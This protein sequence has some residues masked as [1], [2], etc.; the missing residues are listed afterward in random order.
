[1]IDHQKTLKLV[2]KKF[3]PCLLFSATTLDIV[4]GVSPVMAMGCGTHPDKADIIYEEDEHDCQQK[5]SASYLLL[6]GGMGVISI[7]A[8][9]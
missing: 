6:E 4:L 3:I 2:M 5:I 1:M 7:L 8:L 9:K